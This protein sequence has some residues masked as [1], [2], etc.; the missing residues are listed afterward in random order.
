MTRRFLVGGVLAVG[1]G[2]ATLIPAMRRFLSGGDFS[3][4]AALVV[5]LGILLIVGGGATAVLA[6]R[7]SRDGAM[8]APVRAAVMAIIVFLT[9]CGLEF[10]D[11]LLCQDGRVFYWTSVLFLPALGL[12]YGLVS[13][14]RWAWWVSRVAAVFAIVWFITFT[15]LIPFVDL[16]THGVPVPWQGRLYTAGVSVFFASIAA[17]AFHSLGRA[18]ARQYFGKDI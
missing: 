7:R 14:H 18:E 3:G 6:R 2:V 1:F 17:Y 15:V 10:S 5:S 8:P 11:G 12:L 16:R 13:A 9:F 4:L